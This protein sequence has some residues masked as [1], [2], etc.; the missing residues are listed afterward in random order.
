MVKQP[1]QS[2]H[3]PIE[4]VMVGFFWLKWLRSWITQ[5]TMTFHLLYPA[6]P[7]HTIIWVMSSLSTDL[8]LNLEN[9]QAHNTHMPTHTH[10]HPHPIHICTENFGFL[11]NAILQCMK[12]CFCDF[13]KLLKPNQQLLIRFAC[14]LSSVCVCIFKKSIPSFTHCVCVCL[15]NRLVSM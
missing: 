11:F 15:W 1:S 6:M 5:V 7:S 14:G 9:S 8:H 2:I 12:Y 4:C 13:W 10:T 3:L